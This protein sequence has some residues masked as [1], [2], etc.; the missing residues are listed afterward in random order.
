MTNTKSE[1]LFGRVMLSIEGTSLSFYEKDLISSS[2]VGGVIFFSRNFISRQQIADLCDEIFSI[3]A[4]IL[5]AVDQEGGRVQRFDKEFSKLPSMQELGDYS[6]KNNDYEICH[7]VGWLMSSELLASGIDISFAPVLD[8]DR[9]TSSIIGDRAFSDNPNLVSTLAKKFIEG[10]NTAGMK[11]TGKHFPGHGGIFEDSHITEPSDNRNYEDLLNR[12]I[13]PFFDLKDK[14]GAVMSAHIVFPKV[15]DKSVGF[16]SKWLK[17]ILRQE[18]HFNGLVFSDDLSMKGS[19][20]KSFSSKAMNS[21]RAGCDM[22]LVCNHP[23]GVLEVV[24]YFEKENISLS[25]KIIT[26]KKSKFPSWNDLIN[27]KKRL[28]IHEIIKKIGD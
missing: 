20:D 22:V 9:D 23:D 24:N 7:D 28:E 16:S 3:K 17:D 13:K 5:I 11:A 18:I 26:M 6:I 14:L 10:M 15:D 12:D 8:V 4:N 21:I 25:E 27:N 1:D 19:G 2:Q